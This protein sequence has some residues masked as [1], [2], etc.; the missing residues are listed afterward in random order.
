MARDIRN[1]YTLGY[2]PSPTMR[3]EGCQ[4]CTKRGASSCGG[5]CAAAERAEA[6][7]AHPSRISRGR[8]R[9]SARCSLTAVIA[10]GVACLVAYEIGTLKTWSY[11]REAQSRRGSDGHHRAASRNC[12]TT[13]D[14]SKA[15]APGELIGRVDIPRLELSA[16][17][18]EGDDE[19]TLSNAVGHLPDTPLPWHR[20]GNVGVAAHRDGLFRRLEAIRLDDEVR[21]V[22]SRGEY[23]YKVKKTY[24]VDP[25]DVWVLAPTGIATIR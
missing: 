12:R 3:G 25:D 22:T 21:F 1:M 8:G 9:G 7:G 15:L 2:V 19:K 6:G 16:A 18:A 17:V 4:V 5:R 13:P 20:Q 10:F 11:Q 24:I 14:V 23:H